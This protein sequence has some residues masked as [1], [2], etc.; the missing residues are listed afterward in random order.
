MKQ[1]RFR[2]AYGKLNREQKEAVDTIE[3]PLMVVAGPGTGKTQIL[4]LRIANILRR[5][6]SWPE[7]IL[8]LTFTE[9][10]AATMRERLKEI[11]GPAAYGAGIYTFHGFCN[12]VIERHPEAFSRI[13]GARPIAEAE[14]IKLI[15]EIISR[16]SWRRLKPF[17]NPFYY[18]G[19]LLRMINDLK[20]EGIGVED[21]SKIV[22]L[23]KKE[24]DRVTKK[25]KGKKNEWRAE[26]EKLQEIGEFYGLYEKTLRQKQYYDFGDMIM[27]VVRELQNNTDLLQEL[28]EK[29]QY[30]LVDEHQDTNRAQNRV[31]E[32][33][34]DFYANPNIF[35]VGDEKQAIFRFQGA[36][37][38]NFIYFR[39][40]YKSARLVVLKNNY[41][42]SQMILDA[43]SGVLAHQTHL[44]AVTTPTREKVRI[45]EFATEKEEL[46]FV[47]RDIQKRI[48]AG[49]APREIAV[50]YRDNKD[51]LDLAKL[52]DRAGLP[53]VSHS[54][55]GI[56][57]DQD[58]RKLIVILDAVADELGEEKLIRALHLDFWNIPPMDIYKI[59]R[60]ARDHRTV[61]EV[62]HSAEIT[63]KLRLAD[64]E[65]VKTFRDKMSAW[66]RLAQNASLDFFF[67]ELVR[68]SGWLAQAFRD[69]R[70]ADKLEKINGFFEEIKKI[71]NYHPQAGLKDL[72][73][74]IRLVEKYRL[75]TERR[76]EDGEEAINLLTAHKA[77]GREF[78]SV[79]IIKVR[80]GHWG[81][82][83]RPDRLRLPGA[84]F[85]LLG[86][87]LNQNDNDDERRLFY[88][89][90]T[91][92][93][94]FLTVT[95][96][97]EAEGEASFLPSIFLAE[98]KKEAVT[99]LASEK[100]LSP[101]E[102]LWW[103][104]PRRSRRDIDKRWIDKTLRKQGFSVTALNNYL[105]CPWRYFYLNL[106]LLPE[107][108]SKAAKYGSVIHG[109][110]KDCFGRLP[111]QRKQLFIEERL[112]LHASKEHLTGAETKEVLAKGRR[113]LK[114][115]FNFYKDKFFSGEVLAELNIPEVILADHLRLRGKLDKLEVSADGTVNVVDY[116]TRSPKSRNEIEGKTK[117][118][119]GNEKRQLVFYKLLLDNY[120]Y[121]GRRFRMVSGE[122]DFIEPDGRGRYRKERFFIT[123]EEVEALKQLIERT[124]REIRELKFY[125]QGCGA[126]DCE[127]CF[128]RES[129][130]RPIAEKIKRVKLGI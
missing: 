14:R 120:V 53:F 97:R 52:L 109:V 98:L 18:A 6:D 15:E 50:I 35:V 40:K 69:H 127:F 90:L 27:E 23:E 123:P 117:H 10:G 56:F 82:R 106:L 89:A 5:T 4:T 93:R 55:E 45:G 94:R 74:Y 41:R 17:N 130:S 57:R 13:V 83:R 22:R 115:Y 100:R 64:A 24:A 103:L 122:I 113:T 33:L 95:Y 107:V 25:I 12:A 51:A 80:D 119:S 86:S 11:I 3:G 36:S 26:A 37:L 60:A 43:A 39:K 16:Y 125:D 112:R 92:A 128:L 78:E 28:Q 59:L 88:V 68:D 46:F 79:Y 9:A 72:L 62:M 81:N 70:S 7:N 76:R 32:L 87:R 126:A 101:E 91:R 2:E 61:W 30:I 84:V 110:L 73:E 47:V 19:D 65:A 75:R 116:K 31:V 58:I 99:P 96:S 105:K 121:R 49:L 20:R 44:R 54:D 29:Y 104:E 124:V 21:F 34:G 63:Q 42:S 77:K 108:K 67:A 38:E 118:A 1:G 8:A 85:S 48:K 114:G 129:L 111:G 66:R 102:K 71:A